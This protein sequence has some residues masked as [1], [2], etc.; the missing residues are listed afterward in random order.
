MNFNHD[1]ERILIV[2]D[3]VFNINAAKIIMQTVAGIINPN[4]ICDEAENGQ[5]AV[6]MVKNDIAN[7]GNCSYSLIIID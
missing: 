2:D 6:D 3:E 7:N 5:E 1:K 4:S